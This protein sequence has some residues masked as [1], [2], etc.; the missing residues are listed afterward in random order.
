MLEST[1]LGRAAAAA[2][3]N[4]VRER[5]CECECKRVCELAIACARPAESTDKPTN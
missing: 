2:A 4:L 5:E 1:E 3:A